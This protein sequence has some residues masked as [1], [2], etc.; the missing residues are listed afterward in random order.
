LSAVREPAV[1]AAARP[2]AE[3][4]PAAASGSTA[5]SGTERS[6]DL[7]LLVAVAIWSLN[8]TVMK[9]GIA[10]MSPLAFPMF[11]FGLGAIVMTLVLRRREHSLRI[12]RR[13]LGLF[14]IAGFV[15]IT[16]NQISIVYA[17]T[18]TTAANV[19]LL[20]ATQPIF[21]A[22]IATIVGDEVLGR[23]HWAS[24]AIGM[25]GV[26]LIV[27]GGSGGASP[28]SAHDPNGLPLGEL[29]ALLISLTA[30]ASWVTIRRLLERYSAYRILTIQ[31]IIGSVLLLPVAAPALA[32]EDFGAVSAVGW[33]AL[34][35]SAI[36]AGV[37]TNLLYFAGVGRVGPS[38]AAIYQYLQSFLGVVLAV[39]LLSEPLGPLQVI[40]G[41]IVVAS[42]VLSRRRS[43]PRPRLPR[44]GHGSGRGE[45]LSKGNDL[46]TR[47]PALP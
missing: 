1:R 8:F 47:D 21:T 12:E 28:E 33:G 37:V 25:L 45:R 42:V 26:V 29:L 5:R 19:A 7:V 30:A 34:A 10:E 20:S 13:D 35:Y 4:T 6:A 36:L 15:G 27:G 44:G 24:V 40:G 31:M 32:T 18:L 14:V 22:V 39:I 38:R 2:A 11:R 23:R 17:L 43:L 41:L 46:D 16:L 9:V 3:P